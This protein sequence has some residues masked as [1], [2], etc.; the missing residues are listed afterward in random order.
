MSRLAN[1][2]NFG[3]QALPIEA[4]RM[5]ASYVQPLENKTA[6]ARVFDPCAGEGDA[7]DCIAT[8]LDFKRENIYIN[9]LHTQR[10]EA[11]KARFVPANVVNSDALTELYSKRRMFQL[12]YLNPPFDQLGKE[13]GKGRMEFQ[14]LDRL[15]FKQEYVQRG[16]VVII[17]APLN[18]FRDHDVREHIARCYEDD[19]VRFCKLPDELRKYNEVVMFGIV[20]RRF[21]VLEGVEQRAGD[22]VAELDGGFDALP[23]LEYQQQPC[24][25]IPTPIEIGKL[26]WMNASLGTPVVAQQDVIKQGGAWVNPSFIQQRQQLTTRNLQPILPPRPAQAALQ[27]AAGVASGTE[28]MMGGSC[29]IIKGSTIIE[30]HKSTEVIDDAKRTVTVQHNVLRSTP[31]MITLD[32]ENGT[33]RRFVGDEGMRRLMS[34]EG[35]QSALLNAVV[36]AAPPLFDGVIPEDVQQVLDSIVPV[37][38]KRLR[39][40][41]PGY[42]PMQKMLIAAVYRTL[43][44]PDPSWDGAIHR[45]A[46][47]AAEMACGKTSMGIG[48]AILQ[49]KLRGSSIP[50]QAFIAIVSGPN[51]MIGE[52]SQVE[53]W[54]KS[55]GKTPLPDWYAE[56][57]DLC[58]PSWHLEI[59]ESPSEVSAFFKHARDNQHQPHMGF[60]SNSKLRDNCGGEFVPVTLP[61]AENPETKE[62]EGSEYATLH[63]IKWVERA[64]REQNAIKQ[65]RSQRK[66]QS[67]VLV[68]SVSNADDDEAGTSNKQ[69][70]TYNVRSADGTRTVQVFIP[71]WKLDRDALL[72]T[73]HDTRFPSRTVRPRTRLGVACPR[74]ARIV[75]DS[76]GTPMKY[77]TFTGPGFRKVKCEWCYER[78]G[79]VGRERDNVKDRK[80]PLFKNELPGW[81]WS[82]QQLPW[83][84]RPQSNARWPLGLFIAKRYRFD[85]FIPDEVHKYKTMNA[86]IGRVFGAMVNT[87]TK[88]LALTG[89]L[90]GGKASTLYAMLLR[91]HVRPVLMEYG[92]GQETRFVKEC[93]VVDEQ[94]RTIQPKDTSGRYSGEPTSSPRTEERPGITAKLANI[95][96]NCSTQVLLKHMGFK[97]VR[98]EEDLVVL[99]LDPMHK[100]LY[101]TLVQ[102][103]KQIISYGG[104]DALGSYVQSTLLYPYLPWN[105]CGIYSKKK[106]QGYSPPALPE[107]MVLA[108]HEWL[109]EFIVS[110]KRQGRRVLV[111]VQHTLTRDLMPDIQK[112][113]T[114]LARERYGVELKF[115]ILRST[116][117][118]SGMRKAWFAAREQDGT[119]V[120][121]CNPSLVETGLNLIGWPSLV[122]LEVPYSLYTLMQWKKRAFRPTQT[123]NCEV[124]FVCYRNTMSQ[125]AVKLVAKK[126]TAANVLAGDDLSGPMFEL[127]DS[128][129][130]LEALAK[131]LDSDEVEQPEALQA[132]IRE[133]GRKTEEEMTGVAEHEQ[134]LGVQPMP[135]VEAVVEPEVIDLVPPAIQDIALEDD[136]ATQ[137][138]PVVSVLQP[139]KQS[140]PPV[141]TLDDPA[142]VA[143]PVI[144]VITRPLT[145]AEMIEQVKQEQDD[146]PAEESSLIN[147]WVRLARMAAEAKLAKAAAKKQRK[148]KLPA[149]VEVAQLEIFSL[150]VADTSDE[151]TQ[152]SLF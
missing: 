24:Y 66:K 98:Y 81:N 115:G 37:S 128:M 130:L 137:A 43:W 75:R 1:V 69:G 73:T 31:R 104:N 15:I 4:A 77:S 2:A 26:R 50:G 135:I 49:Y 131:T 100:A 96:Q 17:V 41:K 33:V 11:C 14:F 102:K 68:D 94:V 21:R 86:A 120:V 16:G 25:E 5:I 105:T 79:Q 71:Q 151:P 146:E 110:R 84:K 45:A 67:A 60:I 150:P 149:N 48:Q 138:T 30:S 40:Y 139:S 109:A 54:I 28:F 125:Q 152:L 8:V 62:M 6:A 95:V 36:E 116:T 90:Y 82:K 22:V 39:G 140:M 142:N 144:Q 124:V 106:Q 32:M 121:L 70:V 46:F 118:T 97:L 63:N 122:A 76:K 29:N 107:D 132:L 35:V 141:P 12:A 34:I 53:N 80:L 126:G 111:G 143:A 57:V 88:T 23:V 147:D 42:V 55:K 119:D 117:V 59:L 108:H 61:Y 133:A 148:P 64:E 85:L 74:C 136:H 51:H 44:Q 52:R 134:M 113:V 112:K 93:G 89:T 58:G 145:A 9:E 114:E 10:Y 56:A 129:N 99:D 38:G 78:M 83:G 72:R 127:D 3:Y 7:I 27:L 92:Y 13:A 20:R 123:V 65:L 19:S 87:A 101:D 47:L 18:T 91:M 103:G